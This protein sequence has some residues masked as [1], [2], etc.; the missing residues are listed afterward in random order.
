MKSFRTVIALMAAVLIATAAWAQS[1]GSGRIQGKVVDEAGQPIENAQVRAQMQ[2]QTELRTAK[3]NKKGEFRLNNLADGRWK[4]E[5]S[6]EGLDAARGTFD[7]VNETAEPLTITMG[8]PKPD[9][10]L[11]INA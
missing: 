2:G 9:P 6:K 5:I 1:S 4:I 3:T 8:K 10:S 7:I 11:A